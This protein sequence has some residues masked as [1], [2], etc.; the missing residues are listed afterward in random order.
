MRPVSFSPAYIFYH[1]DDRDPSTL[2][3]CEDNGLPRKTVN[4]I[5]SAGG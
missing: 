5:V 2:T 3:N 1:I 4:A